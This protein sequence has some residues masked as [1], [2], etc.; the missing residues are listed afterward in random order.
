MNVKRIL[1]IGLV[2][3]AV[4]ASISFVAADS[5]VKVGGI[6]FSIPDGYNENASLA[7]DEVSGTYPTKDGDVPCK[8][9]HKEFEKGKDAIS[10]K[11]FSCDS[12]DDAKKIF[13][14]DQGLLNGTEK[15][16]NGQKGSYLNETDHVEFFYYK[17]SNYIAVAAND[18]SLLD[19]L[20][21]K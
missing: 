19:K 20:V 3:V 21:P 16:I 18:G 1:L 10:I 7:M 13:E 14:Y 11:V 6:D 9:S 17:D 2:L 15:T 4:A 12:P 8:L 5:S